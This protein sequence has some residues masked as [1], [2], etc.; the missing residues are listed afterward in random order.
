VTRII[1]IALDSVGIDPHGHDRPES[2]YAQSRFLF[3]AG[4]TGN[5]LSLP[6]SPIPGA[7]V[8]TNVVGDNADGAIECAITYTSI[9]SGQSALE[10]HG[11][12]H[13]LGLKEEAFQE[14][15]RSNNLFGNF[16][17]PCL[18]NAV[19]PV[20]LSFLGSSYVQDL[21]PTKD[22]KAI[23][24]VLRYEGQPVRLKGPKKYGFAE[25]FTLGEINQNIFVYAALHAGLPLRTWNDVRQ[26]RAL[27]GT[28]TH[29]LE[30]RFNWEDLGESALP[31]RSA[32]EAA[33]VLVAL[34]NEHDFTFYKYQLADLVSHTGQVE[35]AR[36]V[37]S[38]IESFVEAVL[39]QIDAGETVVIIT[40]DH[41]H[42]EQVAF[43]KGHPKS[44]VPTWYFGQEPETQADQ[45]RRPE[46]VFHVIAKH[47][48]RM[49]S[50]DRT[51]GVKPA[52]GGRSVT[53]G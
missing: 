45:M 14:M 37:F 15:V 6:D 33:R 20:H 17:N 25:L 48:N 23:E 41:G 26:N 46:G 5:L 22:R 9:F 53:P 21:L 11:L 49:I 8:E 44:R 16:L 29:E 4:R 27:T 2:V 3:P 50:A 31:I 51:A 42:L 34:A 19:F 38:R 24:A 35:L 36:A 10:Q 7:L 47:G 52:G 1:L 13:G 30:S 39:K 18:A 40:S 43:T 12:M 32:E 28:M